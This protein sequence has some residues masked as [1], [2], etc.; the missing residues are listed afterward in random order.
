[1][2]GRKSEVEKRKEI[3]ERYEAKIKLGILVLGL[4]VSHVAVPG[5]PQKSRK[6]SAAYKGGFK[7]LKPILEKR[8]IPEAFR[9]IVHSRGHNVM[10][11]AARDGNV[12]LIKDLLNYKKH[13]RVTWVTRKYKVPKWL[14]DP[15]SIRHLYHD[16]NRVYGGRTPL[17]M[18]ASGNKSAHTEVVKLLIDALTKGGSKFEINTPKDN[19]GDNPG[20]APL[21]FSVQA[22]N[23]E[24]VKLLMAAD[25]NTNQK[26]KTGATPVDLAQKIKDGK[27][28][29]YITMALKKT[30]RLDGDKEALF[31]A[32]KTGDNEFVKEVLEFGAEIDVY[33]EDGNTP[34]LYAIK[35]YTAGA[36]DKFEE[37]IHTLV[38]H[39]VPIKIGFRYYS[40]SKK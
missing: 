25:A 26:T 36:K 10:M 22:G 8:L 14:Y 1:M 37:I 30:D 35:Q 13:Y 7:A 38:G 27:K 31:I 29:I 39:N 9:M 19:S 2:I 32:L 6:I 40:L 15:K 18:A 3:M 16:N 23:L 4:M 12:Q 24:S 34:L 11:L 28:R 21:H 17:S 20:Y 5:I 33:D